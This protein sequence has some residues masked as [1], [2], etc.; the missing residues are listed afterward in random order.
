[1]HYMMETVSALTPPSFQRF[2]IKDG[3]RIERF[4]MFVYTPIRILLQYIGAF[5]WQ[6]NPTRALT[7]RARVLWD[8]ARRRGIE[9]K[10]LVLFGRPVEF[11]AAYVRGRWHYFDAIPIA[12]EMRGSSYAWMDDKFTLKKFLEKSDIPVPRG[13]VAWTRKKAL[14]IFDALRK[15]VIVKPRFGSHG[16]HSVTNISTRAQCSDAFLIASKLCQCVVVEEHLRGSVYRATYVN[17]KVLGILRGDPPQIVGDGVSSVRELIETKNK[18][19]PSRV[20]VFLIDEKALDF[21]HRQN[22][23]LDSVL[24]IRKSW[25]FV[26][27]IYGR[28]N[29]KDSSKDAQNSYHCWRRFKSSRSWI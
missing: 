2:A 11:Y 22:L 1:M 24:S 7:G 29:R 12:P 4:V 13:D 6:D 15:P 9:M 23:D 25:S 26:R 14:K 17:G 18:V 28:G 20:A 10:Q 19:R 21:I 27:W 5:R 16:R 3:S 8:E